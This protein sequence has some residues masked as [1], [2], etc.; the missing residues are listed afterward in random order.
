VVV[1]LNV[2]AIVMAA[3]KVAS[4]L[5]IDASFGYSGLVPRR[6]KNGDPILKSKQSGE[7]P[8]P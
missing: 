5:F 8:G 1:A 6:S 7:S 3:S 4:V 2:A